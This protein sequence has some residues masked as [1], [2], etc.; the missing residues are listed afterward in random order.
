MATPKKVKNGE[1]VREFYSSLTLIS[2]YY[3]DKGYRKITMLFNE[4]KELNG[5]KM[6]LASFR[7]HFKKHIIDDCF[8]VNPKINKQQDLT[9]KKERVIS[10]DKDDGEGP[11]IARPN[12]KKVPKF[13]PHTVDVDE[14][15]LL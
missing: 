12:F 3:N 8:I 1:A 6:S 14:D 11:K 4:L 10:L 9:P 2:E 13:N 5:W 15:R 7:Y